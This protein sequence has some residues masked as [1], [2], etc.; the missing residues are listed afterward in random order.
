MVTKKAKKMT[1]RKSVDTL[2]NRVKN[3]NDEVIQVSDNLVDAS[4]TAGAKWQKLM[5]KAMKGGVV[6]FGK[7]QELVLDALEEL[8]GQY[9]YGN[10]RFR[11]LTELK[12]PKTQKGSKI[13]KKVK[14]EVVE[15]SKKAPKMKKEMASSKSD[16]ARDDLKIIDGIGPKI[17]T[18]I[19]QAGIM[20]FERLAATGLEDLKAI[21][22]KAGLKAH[23]PTTWKEQA[24]L[25]IAG[26]LTKQ[27]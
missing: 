18:L 14:A 24:K 2:K 11:K 16:I 23:D 6:L 25:A 5:A 8:K 7:Q 3:L 26:K 22:E 20:T 9:A 21:L 13:A 27:S 12:Q 1:I 19:N 15:T 17:E 4:L 10:K